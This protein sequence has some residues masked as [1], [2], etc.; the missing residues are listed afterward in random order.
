MAQLS[1]YSD[2]Q[3]KPASEKIALVQM[4]AS[5][6]LMGWVLNSGSVYKLTSFDYQVI[7][8][9]LDSGTA[10]TAVTSLGAVT[11]G[12]YYND[13]VNKILYLQA[14]DSSNPNSRFL[15]MSYYYFFSN[16][17]L[18]APWDLNSGFNVQWLDL[19]KSTSGFDVSL[20]SQYQLG[21]AI[22]GSA[23]I[24]LYNDQSFWEPIFDKVYFENQ[25]ITIYS[26]NRA[27]PITQ[28]K[29]IYIGKVQGKA[30]SADTV[31]FTLLDMINQLRSP[32]PLTILQSYPG[33]R[34]PNA[35]N[36]ALQR[37]LYGFNY[38]IRPTNVD[39][40]I[41]SAPSSFTGTVAVTSGSAT[42][43][44]TGTKFTSELQAN[45]I[46]TI[47][48]D[49]NPYIILSVASDTSATLTQNYASAGQSAVSFSPIATLGYPMTG[50]V[51]PTNG[52]TT[53]T[54]SGTIFLT[55]LRQNDQIYIGTEN[56]AYT[57]KSITSD[58]TAVLTQNYSG[59]SPSGSPCYQKPPIGKRWQNRKFLVAGHSLKE[60][61][62]TI[63]AVSGNFNYIYV[64][65]V[66]DFNVGDNIIVTGC[67]NSTIKAVGVTSSGQNFMALTIQLNAIPA[68]GTTV[69][70]AAITN[71]YLGNTLL[72]PNTDYTY[73]ASNATL[74]LDKLCEYNHAS[75]VTIPGT[76][77]FTMGSTAVVGTG[78]TFTKS[79]RPGDWIA[80][81][82]EG[83]FYEIRSITDDLNLVLVSN[84]A[85]TN[86]AAL[87]GKSPSYY[88]EG[89]TVLSC[90]CI[91]A[92][93]NGTTTGVFIKT[94]AQIVKDLL[95]RGGYSAQIDSSSFTT[96]QNICMYKLGLQIPSTYNSTKIPTL[97]DTI[98]QVNQSVFG[99]LV[100]TSDFLLGYQIFSPA[101]L[102]G[103]TTFRE[104][105]VLSWTVQCNSDRI[106]KTAFVNYLYKEYDPG[107]GNGTFAQVSATSNNAQYL[108]LSTRQSTQVTLLTNAV[109]AQMVANRWAFI[110]E[111]ADAVV[112]L[113]MKMQGS[114]LKATDAIAFYHEKLYQRIG[115]TDGRKVGYVSG[116][117]KTAMDT[118]LNVEDLANSFSRCGCIAPIGAAAYAAASKLDKML[119]GYITDSYGLS[120]N[121]DGST[122]GTNLIW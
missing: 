119:N 112:T 98:N 25:Q 12:K 40:I 18:Q 33:V 114:R 5:K 29:I 26:W 59:S 62:T 53:L 66:T 36:L 61:S 2:F 82:T 71:V 115:S 88:V 52:S 100:Q 49:L 120:N 58:T 102:S 87:I 116:I 20:D 44:G 118:T 6:R 63:S 14:S 85:A 42:L 67:G 50:T 22:E 24:T 54:G 68:I 51:A 3:S 81:I 39:Q 110:Q 96:A 103:L 46:I 65:D 69:V 91:G 84:A 19:L 8:S 45:D 60:P 78:T 97:R 55:E 77:T 4:A 113:G 47:G 48:N 9:I 117:Q 15:A 83:V 32:V 109:E 28:A 111:V 122:F 94:A 105:D 43:T 41:R 64:N 107:S 93:E 37:I 104:C 90:D 21:S 17:P 23:T 34:V 80:N 11:A 101:R 35:L 106:A 86:T 74:T 92:T 75:T 13:R 72:T 16:V 57:I 10:Y 89:Q 56:V 73:S 31:S 27:L 30:Y 121:G 99:A 70:R 95:I 7:A 1:L 76:A 38:G 108:A 79:L